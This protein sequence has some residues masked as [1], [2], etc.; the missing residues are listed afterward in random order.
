MRNHAAAPAAAIAY[1][2]CTLLERHACLGRSCTALT[3][4]IQVLNTAVYLV[5]HSHADSIRA[6][7]TC[8]N[9]TACSM[10]CL[11]WWCITP[12]RLLHAL[13]QALCL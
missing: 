5:L 6:D 9:S 12:S 11:N 1:L 7:S 13:M 2:A 4:V 3:Q 10:G 8:S